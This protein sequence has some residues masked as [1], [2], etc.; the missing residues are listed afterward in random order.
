MTSASA[1]IEPTTLDELITRTLLGNEPINT[2]FG[3]DR[4]T[5]LHAACEAGRTT[6]ARQALAAGADSECQDRDNRRPLHLAAG[7][8][9]L[10]CVKL[11]IDHGAFIEAYT[12]TYSH[13]PLHLAARGNHVHCLTTLC[14]AG[15]MVDVRDRNHRTAVHHAAR[16]GNA[17]CIQVLGEFGAHPSMRDDT[18]M[19]PLFYALIEFPG[20]VHAL[21]EAGADIIEAVQVPHAL[22]IKAAKRLPNPQLALMLSAFTGDTEAVQRAL[23]AGGQARTSL[24]GYTPL[25]LAGKGGQAHI[26]ELLES[27][28]RHHQLESAL[29]TSPATER[30]HAL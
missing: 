27:E 10:G 15:A 3:A 23:D 16:H 25:T 2:S 5:L 1:E 13:T 29:K 22:L 12:H 20:A 19:T 28:R 26:V 8:G 9:A 14:E 11:L 30:A 6:V 7:T 4:R 24:Y 21:C 18:N 17:E